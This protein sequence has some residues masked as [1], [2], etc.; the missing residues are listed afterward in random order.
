MLKRLAVLVFAMLSAM[1]FAAG[2]TTLEQ[3]KTKVAETFLQAMLNTDT[4]M[5]WQILSPE[6]RK[7]MIA[8]NGSEDAAIKSLKPF[9][10]NFLRGADIGNIRKIFNDPQK[11]EIQLRQFVK[12]LEQGLIEHEGKWYLEI[13]KF[14]RTAKIDQSTK[15]AAMETFLRATADKDIETFWLLLPPAERLQISSI[16][17]NVA[18]AKK[19]IADT[20]TAGVDAEQALKIKSILDSEFK[21]QFLDAAV[22]QMDDLFVQIDG[23]WYLNLNAADEKAPAK[24]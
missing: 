9:A 11:K 14:S 19:V 17:D 15:V 2:E 20:F 12:L 5:L 10:D 8:A 7:M 24:Q 21:T 4:A 3:S 16:A 13:S 23:K 18:E 22:I 6:S 1:L